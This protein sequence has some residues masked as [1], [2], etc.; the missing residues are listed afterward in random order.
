MKNKIPIQLAILFWVVVAADIIGIAANIAVLHFIAKPLLIPV[1]LFLL[2]TTKAAV[3]RK[4]LLLIGLF[5]SWLGDIF[6]LLESSYKLFFIF[7]LVCFL[8]THIFYIIYFLK[9]QPAAVSLLKKQPLLFL[10]VVGYG[11]SLVY[12]L[13]PHLNEL[14]IPV[15]V[16]AAVI[17]TML[18][19]SLHIFL[20]VNTPANIFYVAGA[21]LFVL[22][23]S[24]L[25]TDKF[26]QPFAYAGVCIM[27]TYCAAQF[28][29]V[30]GFIKQ[31]PHD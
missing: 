5:F 2:G 10:L 7:G 1:L 24:L 12:F 13:Y 14:K 28:F 27:L 15:M 29:I 16:Y 20:K 19:C 26:Y 3:P 31:L 4:H 30:T 23:D 18:L 17:C 22:S 25:A 8:T 6:L 9:I 11:I 21:A